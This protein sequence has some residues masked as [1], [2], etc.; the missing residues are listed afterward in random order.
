MSTPPKVVNDDLNDY[1][2]TLDRLM[3]NL[4]SLE[5]ALRLALYTHDPTERWIPGG[6]VT[7]LTPGHQVPENRLFLAHARGT[8]QGVQQARLGLRGTP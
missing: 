5:P 6:N 8:R 2:N 7:T 4:A 1:A 3:G